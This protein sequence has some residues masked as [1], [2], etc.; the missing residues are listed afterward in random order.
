MMEEIDRFQ[1]PP[2]NGET[3]PLVSRLDVSITLF[4][5]ILYVQSVSFRLNGL[6]CVLLVPYR[7]YERT[8]KALCPYYTIKSAM[9][10]GYGLIYV[11]IIMMTF[12]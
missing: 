12:D 6:S 8:S 5:Q 4:S 9:L 7:I 10:N 11:A 1:V 3:Q 2:V